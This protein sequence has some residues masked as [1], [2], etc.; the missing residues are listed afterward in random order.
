L[1][2]DRVEAVP[3]LDD[4]Q[5]VRIEARGK[6]RA[7]QL[8]EE[9]MIAANEAI[10]ILLKDVPSIQRVVRS[11]ERWPRIVQ[12]AAG[13]GYQLPEQADAGALAGFLRE[14]NEAH[15]GRYAD[16]SLSVLKLMGPGWDTSDW[17]RTTIHTPLRPTGVLQ[18]L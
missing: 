13:Y 3:V 7:T 14:Q 17:R 4:G 2:F 8:I 18:M 16:L 11:P 10:A 1:Q 15:P 6:N 5:V 12:L 9:L